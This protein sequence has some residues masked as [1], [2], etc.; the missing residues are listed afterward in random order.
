MT[1]EEQQMLV[2]TWQPHVSKETIEEFLFS[3]C[4]QEISDEQKAL[5]IGIAQANNLNPFK[6]EIYPIPFWNTKLGKNDMQ[7]VTA[8]TVYL[9]RA[10]QSGKLN[11]WNIVI[12]EDE[13]KKVTGGKIT[14]YRKDWDNPFEREVSWSEIV[15][16]KKDGT[17]NK[18]WNDKPAFMTKK[19]LIAQ[20]MRLCF[21]EDMGGMP[22]VDAEVIEMEPVP[23][24][25]V[26]LQVVHSAPEII[27]N[28][29]SEPIKPEATKAIVHSWNLSLNKLQTWLRVLSIKGNYVKK[30]YQTQSPKLAIV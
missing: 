24:N 17:V 12:H 13:S 30:S 2:K 26:N 16:T 15:Q 14:I 4:K 21:P 11:G 29:T 25:P 9:Q 3:Q 8:Y 20:G 22:Y 23:S 1:K 5:F 27:D 7:P 28:K 6:R 19:T 18:N 10:Q